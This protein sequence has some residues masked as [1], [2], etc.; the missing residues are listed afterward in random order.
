M[1]FQSKMWTYVSFCQAG[2]C[3]YGGHALS[4][5]RQGCA[6]PHL[7][8]LQLLSNEEDYCWLLSSAASLLG[9]TAENFHRRAPD[10]PG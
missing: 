10:G 7:S 3:A 2:V 4:L 1:G 9:N 5:G 6:G 8:E